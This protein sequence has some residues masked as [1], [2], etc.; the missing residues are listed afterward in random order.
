MRPWG[1][2]GVLS[3]CLWHLS[4]LLVVL[5]HVAGITTSSPTSNAEPNLDKQAGEMT[6]PVGWRRLVS[7]IN[8]VGLWRGC[9]SAAWDNCAW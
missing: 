2:R 8:A 3:K 4:P 1:G 7:L 9:G 5:H 6:F